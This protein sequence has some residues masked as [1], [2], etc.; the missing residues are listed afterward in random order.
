VSLKGES[1]AGKS[2]VLYA[3][4]SVWGEP[5]DMMLNGDKSGSTMNARIAKIG[6]YNNLPVCVDE[7]TNLDEKDLSTLC[8]MISQ[9]H[10]KDRMLQNQKLAE[11]ERWCTMMAVTGNRGVYEK[12]GVNKADSSAEAAR[13]FEMAVDKKDD[14]VEADAARDLLLENY[15]LAGE[16][17]IAFITANLAAV[18]QQVKALMVRADQATGN[19]P[20]GRFWT[21]TIAANIAAGRLA[22]AAGVLPW[23]DAYIKRIFEWACRH[24]LTIRGEVSQTVV[25]PHGILAEFMNE[26]IQNTLLVSQDSSNLKKS[27]ILTQFRGKLFIRREHDTGKAL[28]ARSEIRKYLNQRGVD[29]TQTKKELT[30]QKILL[31]SDLR[32]TLG[33][34]T[35]YASGQ[36]DCWWID[37][38]HPLMSDAV[39]APVLDNQQEAA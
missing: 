21:A 26:N 6:M 5:K 13:A 18:K 8:Y 32:R 9:G 12:L 27:N 31:D 10:G 28:I 39:S 16:R 34:G 20:M 11:D 37:L 3:I 33:Q 19:D 24:V 38:N 22:V 1:G 25:T 23:D 35:Q 30:R 4:N 7:I 29:Y 15:G 2:T 14:K 17:F 36:T